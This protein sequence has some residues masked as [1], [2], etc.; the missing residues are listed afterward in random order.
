VIWALTT[1]VVYERHHEIK[2]F[3]RYEEDVYAYNCAAIDR[4][5][6]SED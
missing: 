4:E 3:D 2:S 1:P 5:K 6:E